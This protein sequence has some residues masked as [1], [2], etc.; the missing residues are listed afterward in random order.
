MQIT[1]GRGMGVRD[2]WHIGNVLTI[3]APCKCWPLL[4]ESLTW[5]STDTPLNDSSNVNWLWLTKDHPP[6]PSRML[7]SVL[8]LSLMWKSLEYIL[9]ILK[10]STFTP[11]VISAFPPRTTQKW[12]LMNLIVGPWMTPNKVLH[13]P[14]YPNRESLQPS[15]VTKPT[16]Y[17]NSTHFSNH[18]AYHITFPFVITWR[19]GSCQAQRTATELLCTWPR[20]HSRDCQPHHVTVSLTR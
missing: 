11:L 9:A 17:S 12:S 7:S 1:R 14:L 19:S 10:S 4:L 2:G 3:A 6:A 18:F 13:A 20:A 15:S 8:S 5:R 16:P